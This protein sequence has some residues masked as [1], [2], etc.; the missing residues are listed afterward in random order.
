M[1]LQERVEALPPDFFLGG[2]KDDFESVGR[3]QL[4]MLTMHGLYPDSKV[5]DI[6]CGCLRGGYWL[7]HFLDSGCYF[8]IERHQG[9]VES[10]IEKILA[11]DILASKKPRFEYNND[12]DSSGFGEKFDVFLARSV[13]T[14]TSKKQI[15][16][17]LD[18]FQRDSTDDAIFLT[19]YHPAGF[20]RRQG[21]SLLSYL[22]AGFRR[23]EYMGEEYV[24][25]A[26][27]GLRWVRD[28]CAKRSLTVEQLAEGIYN[29]Q[30]WLKIS[31]SGRAGSDQSGP[32]EFESWSRSR[33]AT[34]LRAAFS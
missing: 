8:G 23:P 25:F 32:L 27:H 5:L 11:P 18:A 14:H 15:Q 31:K 1:R 3:L 30:V 20:G 21:Q 13:W 17:M 26:F 6:G 34:R 33:A 12:F 19:S 22:R 2:P 28:E 4:M 24:Q 7:I 10:G 9:V 16:S 29:T